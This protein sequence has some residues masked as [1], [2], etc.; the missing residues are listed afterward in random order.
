MAGG[1]LGGG[2]DATRG[3]GAKEA[4]TDALALCRVFCSLLVPDEDG[5]RRGAGADGETG[6]RRSAE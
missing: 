6:A 5:E 1:G 3:G 4:V 2:G